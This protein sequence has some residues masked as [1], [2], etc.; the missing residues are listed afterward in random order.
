MRINIYSLVAIF[1]NIIGVLIYFYLGYRIS[2]YFR[3]VE[4][5]TEYLVSIFIFTYV[6]FILLS[7]YFLII[8][9]IQDYSKLLGLYFLWL[10]LIVSPAL[11]FRNSIWYGSSF[12][13]AQMT[14]SSD[15]VYTLEYDQEK[16]RM[17]EIDPSSEKYKIRERAAESEREE[18]IDIDHG[19]YS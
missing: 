7:L 15:W 5:E 11:S 9:E 17:V 16:K 3:P 19:V 12:R 4:N 10:A 18:R 6:P 2:D 8:K 13:P 14:D 1:L